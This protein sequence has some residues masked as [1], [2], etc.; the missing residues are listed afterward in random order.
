ML[1][2]NAYG[3]INLTL[4]ILGQRTDGYHEIRSIM[5]NI[6]LHDKLTFEITDNET[7]YLSGN[8][9]F[10]EY[11]ENNLIYKSAKV[12]MEYNDKGS[13]VRIYLNKKIPMEAGLAG[14]SA[15]AAATLIGLNKLWELNLSI[16][17][18]IDIGSHIG[19]DIPFCLV[20]NTALV[21]GRGEKV[22]RIKS[23]PIE[24]LLVVKPDFGA[25]TK[26]IY[27]KYDEIEYQKS[28]NHTDLMIREIIDQG[29]YKKYLY[30]E[31]EKVTTK[32]YPEVQEIIDTMHQTCKYVMMSGSGPTCFAFGDEN[33]INLLYE[34]FKDKYKD[35]LITS[36][37]T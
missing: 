4:E 37:K 18:L 17:K 28:K 14:G 13:G 35:V 33:S 8:C 32:L 7:I 36:L 26:L 11:D 12:L 1:Q 29:N 20:G 15:D 31:L 9:P 6:K 24:K 27:S 2:I 25:S 23:P 10:L 21:E 5:Q 22:T 30:N 34:K 16:D 19:S 3:K